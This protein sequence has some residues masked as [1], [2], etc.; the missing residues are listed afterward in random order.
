[1]RVAYNETLFE[2]Q[3][4][5]ST[6]SR[7]LSMAMFSNSASRFDY[8]ATLTHYM[9][10]WCRTV[11]DTHPVTCIDQLYSQK[12]PATATSL[13]VTVPAADANYQFAVEAFQ[14]SYGSGMTWSDCIVQANGTGS[15]IKQVNVV[16]A[17]STTLNVNWE[18]TCSVRG[19]IVTAFNVHYCQVMSENSED[20]DCISSPKNDR[21]DPAVKRH[22][23][24]NL[25]PYTWYKISISV[26]TR[27][28]EGP[29]SPPSV[30]RTKEGVPSAPLDL[31]A[32]DVSN[33]SLSIGWRA[34]SIPNGPANYTYKVLQ[35]NLIVETTETEVFFF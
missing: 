8:A 30:N 35:N 7:S 11:R 4:E 25:E 14:S 29:N 32:I 17:T 1:M 24:R 21:V 28:G 19:G 16:E 6:A 2:I 5:P 22:T 12:V 13:N 10:F 26:E 27:G 20:S 18:L 9:V 15:E 31:N 3:W 34:P 33:V 23:L